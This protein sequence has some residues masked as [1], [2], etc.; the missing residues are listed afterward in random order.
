MRFMPAWK[1][2]ATW[3]LL[4][5]IKSVKQS[6]C[7]EGVL[8]RKGVLFMKLFKRFHAA[9]CLSL[10]LAFCF[11]LTV[12]AAKNKSP[13]AVSSVAARTSSESAVTLTWKK[14][15]GATAYQV[16]MR[17]GTSGE[18]T[19]IV[20][21]AKTSYTKRKLMPGRTYYFYIRSV[22][23][24]RGANYYSR[25]VSKT[26][27]AKPMIAALAAPSTFKIY[28]NGNGKFY[29]SWTKV[30]NATGYVLFQYNSKT[31]KYKRVATSKSV[32]AYVSRLTA[33]K[34]YK[35]KLRA[36]RT[37]NGV[38]RYG[39]WSSVVTKKVPAVSSSV[40]SVRTIW[41][42]ATVLSNV[43]A[44]PANSKSKHQLVKKGTK[45]TVVAYGGTCKV[46][47][48]N[49]DLVYIRLSNLNFTS[50]IYTKKSYSKKLKED[51]VN[52]SGYSS[53]TKYLIWVSTYTQEYCLYTGSAG[54]WKLLR[55]AKIATGKA[56][57]P[58]ATHICKIRGR[59]ERWTY[60][61]GTYQAPIVYFYGKNAFHSRLHNPD[62]T[63]AAPNIGK[64]VSGGCIRMYDED[65]QYIYDNCPNGTTVVIY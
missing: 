6:T 19:R 35:F 52:Q 10:L 17:T 32:N 54:K 16:Y 61:N 12:F 64:P 9:I 59:E 36:Y 23:S 47:L 49:K 62:G 24:S 46:Q 8:L 3:L 56:S 33:G 27:K 2:M 14:A 51:Y 42:K 44:S 48:P 30:K 58:T 57:S 11:S 18:F 65:V 55:T 15:S 50:S 60:E 45:V 38:T 7:K 40:A 26:V 29:F 63:I 21:T 41:Y 37:V 34:T 22:R 13:A 43:T 28:K 4:T 20:T 5:E 1:S 39:P 53:S 25:S 31:K